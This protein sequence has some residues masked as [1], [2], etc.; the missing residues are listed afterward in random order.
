M[1]GFY[2][3]EQFHAD[4]HPTLNLKRKIRPMKAHKGVEV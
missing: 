2:I 1:K 4:L 3:H